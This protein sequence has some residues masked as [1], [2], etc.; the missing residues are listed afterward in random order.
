MKKVLIMLLLLV[1][2]AMPV[3]ADSSNAIGQWICDESTDNTATVQKALD[4]AKGVPVLVPNG[5]YFSLSALKFPKNSGKNGYYILDYRANDDTSSPGHPS[6]SASNERIRFMQN[7]NASGYNNDYYFNSGYSTG[8]G[9]NVRRDV[10]APNIGSGQDVQY[11]RVSLGWMQ[12]DLSRMQLKYT[13]SAG[14]TSSPGLDDGW[15]AQFIE[16]R[17]TLKNIKA[18]SFVAPLAVNN[19]VKGA[20]SGARGWVKQIAADQIKVT[21]LSGKFVAG[22]AV[23]LEPAVETT[24]DKISE[25]TGPA[26]TSN[27]NR[28]GLSAKHEGQFFSNLQGDDAIYPFN[29]GGILAIQQGNTMRGKYADAELIMADKLAAPARLVRV[30]LETS[31][32]DL[33]VLNTTTNKEVFRLHNANGMAQ[34]ITQTVVAFSNIETPVISVGAVPSTVR[35]PKILSGVGSPEGVVTAGT[36]SLYLNASGGVNTTLYV[37]TSGTGNTGWTAK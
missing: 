12:D 1:I 23:I 17:M 2:A 31:T 30:K 8:L 7:S 20:T 33:V 26:N 11:G 24:K 5:A 28:L 4:V 18:S 15:T 27:S 36:G 35:T 6:V 29:I 25:V 9:L 34:A 3:F 22:E 21:L 32:G 10:N 14:N 19:M 37:K 13:D 16:P